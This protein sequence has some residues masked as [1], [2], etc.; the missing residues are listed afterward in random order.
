MTDNNGSNTLIGSTGANVLR[1]NGGNDAIRGGGGAD[2]LDGGNGR[3]T[4]DGGM[5]NDKLKGGAG[6]DSFAFST[7]LS[8]ANIDLIQAFNV[9]ADTIR[10]DNAVFA[11]LATGKLL[12]GAFAANAQGSAADRGDRIIY[13]TNS[14]ELYYDSDGNGAG[15]RVHFATL[16]PGLA[17]TA[18][19][20]FVF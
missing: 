15:L 12:N 10:L 20:F 1:G 2:T 14:G 17:L 13:D 19:D 8:P 4:L 6:A 18:A 7:K 9:A 3:D 11:S 5:G 16:T